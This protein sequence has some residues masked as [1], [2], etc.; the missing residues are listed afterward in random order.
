MKPQII[1]IIS[2]SDEIKELMLQYA[3]ASS[4]PIN[5]EHILI[6]KTAAKFKQY[7]SGFSG[8]VIIDIEKE[9]DSILAICRD[10]NFDINIITLTSKNISHDLFNQSVPYTRLEKPISIIELFNEIERLIEKLSQESNFYI[11]GDY[12]FNFKQAFL[13]KGKDIFLLTEKEAGLIMVLYENYQTPLTKK[14]I[15]KKVWG[16]NITMDTHTLETHI[17][18][19]RQKIKNDSK[20]LQTKTNGYVLGYMN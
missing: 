14:D 20:F 13:R 2:E 15:L 4:L 8:V 17:Y 19:L 7:Y 3:K 12:Q 5:E 1:C 16:Y 11:I 9:I 6:F 10:N 18:R